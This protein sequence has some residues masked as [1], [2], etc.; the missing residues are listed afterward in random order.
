MP[1]YR[2]SYRPRYGA[3]SRRGRRSYPKTKRSGYTKRKMGRVSTRSSA[4]GVRAQLRDLQLALKQ[5]L[6]TK[7]AVKGT[8]GEI[9]LRNEGEDKGNYFFAP[10]SEILRAMCMQRQAG[11]VYVTGITFEL[12]IMHHRGVDFFALCAPIPGV[13]GLP[14]IPVGGDPPIFPIGARDFETKLGATG[15]YSMQDPLVTAVEQ[16]AF[17]GRSRDGTL[18]DA[19]LRSGVLPGAQSTLNG[20]KSKSV[21]SGRVAMQLS[22]RIDSPMSVEDGYVR[23]KIR[24]YWPINKRIRVCDSAF[25]YIADR[26]VIMCGLRTQ[27]N[28]PQ[29]K[30]KEGMSL[31]PA[32]IRDL[33][34]T[35]HARQ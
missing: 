27:V 25:N 21:L 20:L 13:G 29:L 26:H 19:P 34:V 28:M 30:G 5:G 15:M 6:P 3:S 17:S 4:N 14:V 8:P 22:R 35:V 32:F 23:E 12:D 11:E 1:Y 9:P 10:V 33:Q 31:M 2:R 24:I 7:V 18:F 16:A